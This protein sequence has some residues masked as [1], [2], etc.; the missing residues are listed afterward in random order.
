MKNKKELTLV[1][2]IVVIVILAVF[3][4]VAVPSVMS[5]LD[6]ADTAKMMAEVRGIYQAAQTAAVKTKMFDERRESRFLINGGK[7]EKV[8]M[9]TNYM[10]YYV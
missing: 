3:M 5:Y 7:E 9:V 2:I 10:L 1:E 4:A 6:E 8:T